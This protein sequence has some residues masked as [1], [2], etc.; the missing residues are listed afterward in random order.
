MYFRKK[1]SGVYW[2][3]YRW[4]INYNSHIYRYRCHIETLLLVNKKTSITSPLAL[5]LPLTS[6]QKLRVKCFCLLE[7]N[8]FA[9]LAIRAWRLF[10]CMTKS[11]NTRSSTVGR[12]DL[13]S[14]QTFLQGWPYRGSHSIRGFLSI[15][16]Q[17]FSFVKSKC[18]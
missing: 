8:T 6:F 18:K 15:I 2:L 4:K 17:A 10:V 16:L 12:Y 13:F 9:C 11:N 1:E 5:L 14:H 7:K 3:G